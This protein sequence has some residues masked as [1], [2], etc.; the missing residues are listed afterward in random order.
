[1]ERMSYEA[2]PLRADDGLTYGQ[3][4]AAILGIA[5]EH[6]GKTL[7]VACGSRL[8]AAVVPVSSDLDLK[9]IARLNSVKKARLADAEAVQKATGYRPGGVSPVP[10][11]HQPLATFIDRSFET[12]DEIVVSAGAPGSAFRLTPAE[13]LALTGGSFADIGRPAG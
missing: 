12:A 10:R 6:L 2:P 5:P 1:M 13:L 9:A 8:V 3:R 11:G 7:I 4:A